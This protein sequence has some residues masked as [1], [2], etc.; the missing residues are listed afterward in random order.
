MKNPLA[1]IKTQKPNI[2]GRGYPKAAETK[3]HNLG[4]VGAYKT[5]KGQIK[6]LF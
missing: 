4:N 3:H 1:G 2:E 5:G 6:N